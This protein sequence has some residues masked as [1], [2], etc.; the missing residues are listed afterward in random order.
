MDEADDQKD[1]YIE[2]LYDEI[3]ELDEIEQ[4]NQELFDQEFYELEDEI[5]NLQD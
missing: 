4:E 1:E 2:E 5:Q 3:F